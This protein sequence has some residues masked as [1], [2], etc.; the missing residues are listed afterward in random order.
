MIR[1]QNSMGF[2]PNEK[3]TTPRYIMRGDD[4]SRELFYLP[5]NGEFKLVVIGEIRR[6]NKCILE[7]KTWDRKCIYPKF[8]PFYHPELVKLFR[9]KFKE[10]RT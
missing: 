6:N 10:G 4:D 8:C 7:D 1:S 3:S 5:C 2:D 9:E